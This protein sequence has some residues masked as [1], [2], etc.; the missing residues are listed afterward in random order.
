MKKFFCLLIML[1]FFPSVSVLAADSKCAP[2]IYN[3]HSYKVFTDNKTWIEAENYCESLGGH[4][5]TITSQEEMDFIKTLPEIK[6]AWIGA[7]YNNGWIWIT[8]ENFSFTN[9]KGYVGKSSSYSAYICN[10]SSSSAYYGEWEYQSKSYSEKYICEWDSIIKEEYHNWKKQNNGIK[11]DDVYHSENYICSNCESTKTEGKVEHNWQPTYNTVGLDGNYHGDEYECKYCGAITYLDLG[12]HDWFREYSGDKEIDG[13][14]H[15]LE[16][17]CFYCNETKMVREKHSLDNYLWTTELNNMYHNRYY[18]CYI[19]NG[20]ACVKK[21][22]NWRATSYV[23]RLNS[24]F[25]NRVYK[26]HECGILKEFKQAHKYNYKYVYKKATLFSQGKKAYL[27]DCGR[28]IY[29]KFS[30]CRCINAK[31]CTSYDIKSHS[32]LYKNSKYLTVKL[33]TPLKGA[34]IKVKIGKKIYKKKISNKS[35]TVKIRIKNPPYG[36][37]IDMWVYYKGKYIGD[38]IC[39]WDGET[40]EYTEYDYVY[41]AKDIR[42]GMTKNQVRNTYYWGGTSDTASASGGWSYWYYDDGSYIAFK[43]GKVYYW[44]NAAR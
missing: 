1:L 30:W 35:K 39:G 15:L 34:L 28:E 25:H 13:T 9:W 44:Y 33:K 2:V 11:I 20:Q 6:S 8:G 32:I 38:D 7:T 10:V 43:N 22:H 31:L 23:Y 19:C 5:V 16:Y 24:S 36:K 12:E 27:C 37:R 14:Y 42:K 29:K 26:C 40:N 4:L 17:R 3:G 18:E 41:Y 21:K